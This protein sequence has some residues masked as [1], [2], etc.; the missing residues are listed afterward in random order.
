[1][2]KNVMMRVASV[3]LI[4]VLL[5]SSV[6]SG[7]FAKYVTAQTGDDYARV[8]KFGVEITAIGKMFAKEYDTEDPADAAVVG[9]KSVV[10]G[11]N[12]VAPGTSGELSAIK[13]TG[14]PEVAVEVKYTA[15]VDFGDNW[16][17]AGDVYYCP[18]EI[19]IDGTTYKGT[20]YANI[21]EF[22]A[23]IAKA[24][25]DQSKKYAAGTTLEDD[26]LCA[27]EISWAWAFEGNDDVKDTFLGDAAADGTEIY[28]DID[29]SCTV[30]Q[31]D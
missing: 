4:C 25:T 30:T 10:S 1:M 23:A 5:T 14:T 26:A 22:E 24:I 21:G 9:A 20:D 12:V 15:T 29:L 31:I 7:T 16:K 6:I 3:L 18:I 27:V 2:K 17:V 13:I 28:I 8:A 19:T 11:V